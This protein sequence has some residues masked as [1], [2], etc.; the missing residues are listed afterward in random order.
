MD[1][2]STVEAIIFAS[3][4][5]THPPMEELRKVV[6]KKEFAIRVELGLGSAQADVWTCDLSYEYVKINAEYTT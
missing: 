3:G 4:E 2:K 1:L 5:P 6:G